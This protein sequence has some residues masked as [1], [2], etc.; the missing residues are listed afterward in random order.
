MTKCLICNKKIKDHPGLFAKHLKKHK[1]SPK[2]YFDK[3][4]K[5]STKCPI[6]GEK[7]KFISVLSGYTNT[8]CKKD[9]VIKLKSIGRM[10]TLQDKYGV[11]NISFLQETKDKISNSL[12]NK[13]EEDKKMIIEK[14]RKTYQKNYSEVHYMKSSEAR[15]LFHNINEQRT[16]EEREE[17]NDKLSKTFN[18]KSENEIKII[19]EKIRKTCQKKYG[20]D[21][22]MQVPEIFE[23]QQKSIY[24]YKD[25]ILPSGKII[26]VQGYEP[27]ALDI[28]F[29]Q[30]YKEKDIETSVKNMPNIWYI[31]SDKKKH[32]YFPD[33]FI[34]SENKIIEVKSEYTFNA[35]YE[36]NM[37]K[38]EAC[39]KAG[40]KFEFEIL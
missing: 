13:S 32:R 28:L 16:K 26:K 8:C 31:G 30:G 33:I 7:K 19:N 37:L 1:I 24:K 39:L 22:P 14:R 6:C 35:D 23:K 11:D 25:Y 38:E 17:I 20:V 15:L 36:I 40:Y 29:K 5:I 18:T 4:T 3:F 27:K 10:K 34:I 2:E 12:R 9:C 21:S